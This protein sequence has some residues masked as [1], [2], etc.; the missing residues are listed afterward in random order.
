MRPR[1]RG[2]VLP[3]RNDWTSPTGTRVLSDITHGRNMR[4][5]KPG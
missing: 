2:I 5:V 1:P 3:D 4:G